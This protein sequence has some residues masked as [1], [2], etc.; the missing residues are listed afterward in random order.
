M[1][2]GGPIQS[3]TTGEGNQRVAST[4]GEREPKDVLPE[5]VLRELRNAVA[6]LKYGTITIKVHGSKVAQIEIA[7][8]KRFD[9]A[10]LCDG[11][12]I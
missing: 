1:P 12:G 11:E 7:E 6:R 5:A 10:G 3:K 2:V 8:K 9:D 4:K